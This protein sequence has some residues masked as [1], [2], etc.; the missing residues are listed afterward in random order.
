MSEQITD[1]SGMSDAEIAKATRE[2]RLDAI[3][4]GDREQIALAKAEALIA[5]REATPEPTVSPDMGARSGPRSEKYT[6]A[7]LA[8]AS[9]DQ[10]AKATLAGKLDDLLA[11]R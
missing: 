4:S 10:I 1:I 7:W 2:G 8:T 6:E 3:L 11:G 9:A 5:E